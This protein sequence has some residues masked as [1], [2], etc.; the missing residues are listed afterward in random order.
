MQII[1]PSE[2]FSEGSL[3]W[4]MQSLLGCVL[5][6]AGVSRTM[7][8]SQSAAE[9]HERLVFACEDL[10][11]WLASVFALLEL[12]GGVCL[13]ALGA[14]QPLG[15]FAQMVAWLMAPL[16]AYTALYH[17]RRRGPAAPVI[18][19]FLMAVFVILGYAR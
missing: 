16:L 2:W 19:A 10:P 9:E 1:Q 5:V 6:Y 3:L 17:L 8:R 11:S 15:M 14:F 7:M 4:I 12:V 18:A 13:L